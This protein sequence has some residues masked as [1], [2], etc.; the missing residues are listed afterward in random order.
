MSCEKQSARIAATAAVSAGINTISG[1]AS[2]VIG[3]VSNKIGGQIAGAVQAGQSSGKAMLVTVQRQAGAA[4]EQWVD[5]QDTL[6]EQVLGRV[7]PVSNAVLR[8][9]DRPAVTA[10]KAAPYIAGAL[11]T[12]RVRGYLVTQQGSAPIAAVAVAP[13][14]MGEIMRNRRVLGQARRTI[15]VAGA[16]SA[17]SASAAVWATK[18][19][20]DDQT[21]TLQKNEKTLA[22]VTFQK[23][24]RMTGFLN[25]LDLIGS[26]RLG[27]NVVFSE[28]DV[29]RAAKGG[30]WHRG[31]SVI[32]TPGGQRTI[33]HL[34]S[35]KLPAQHFYFDRK[36]SAG[37]VAGL[38][39][40]HTKANR[41]PGY[42]GEVHPVENLVPSWG[43]TKK[44]MITTR[45]YHPP[46]EAGWVVSEKKE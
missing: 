15:G 43:T 11:A 31:T 7:A 41:L 33:T 36:L 8:K 38:V 19:Q 27:K 29:L 44:A 9:V 23:S 3:A 4:V 6:N 35:L 16:V 20:G 1:K 46:A 40:G 30:A 25:K 32:E 5:T 17:L 34:Q 12:L 21:L 45:L 42:V 14:S 28:G 39:S 37:E 2:N 10:A 18:D 22:E 26:H 13:R 24:A